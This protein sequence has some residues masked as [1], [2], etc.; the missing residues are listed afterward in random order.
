MPDHVL[1]L[2]S[3]QYAMLAAQHG[4]FRRAAAELNVQQSTISKGVRSLEYRLGAKLF[5]RHSAGIR[6]T[7]AGDRFLEDARIGFEQLQRAMRR[8]GALQRGEEG[9]LVVRASMPL[10]LLGDVLDR[11]RVKFEGVAVEVV[12]AT[13]SASCG[14][15]LRR[16]ADL[17]FV[18]R[19]PAG[20]AARSLHLGEARMI[21]ALHKDHPHA[22]DRVL[23]IDDLGREQIILPMRGIGPVLVEHLKRRIE[24]AGGSANIQLHDVGACNLVNMVMR[25]FGVTVMVGSIP[26]PARDEVAFVPLAGK[27]VV[28]LHLVWMEANPNPALK[29]LL[30]LVPR[31][32]PI[33]L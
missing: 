3:F 14:A 6:P 27:H 13:C 25:G 8:V 22:G 4:S 15:V 9:E 20:G 5:E 11:F 30:D 10:N 7:P 19:V 16:E 18:G 28:P 1:D 24:K 17:A 26:Q 31:L 23:T 12:E 32:T 29:Q 33:D 2:R 21:V